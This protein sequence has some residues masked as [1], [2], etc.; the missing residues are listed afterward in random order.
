MTSETTA[1][2]LDSEA[3][4][5]VSELIEHM[6]ALSR[7]ISGANQLS[8]TALKAAALEMD[9]MVRDLASMRHVA[10]SLHEACGEA[11]ATLAD[12]SPQLHGNG[13][14]RVESTVFR[15]HAALALARKLN[16]RGQR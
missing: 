9:S 15:V 16:F 11:A 5:N 7:A 8:T 12:I 14:A 10:H 2:R 6:R 3:P 1:E 13:V 4:R